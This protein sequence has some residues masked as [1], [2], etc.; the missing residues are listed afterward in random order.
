M[1]SMVWLF[2][3]IHTMNQNAY[4]AS[5]GDVPAALTT[6][7]TRSA[8]REQPRRPLQPQTSRPIVAR[9]TYGL[10][11]FRA[12]TMNEG[13]LHER[14]S[15]IHEQW[16]DG[17]RVTQATLLRLSGTFPLAMSGSFGHAYSSIWLT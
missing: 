13:S 3:R 11:G 9:Q 14:F 16:L 2:V 7:A 15:L 1:A 8:P 4:P 5:S 17:M 12:H 10:G 6:R